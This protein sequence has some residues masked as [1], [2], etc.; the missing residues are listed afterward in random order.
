MI[1]IEGM[2]HYN[3]EKML[4]IFTNYRHCFFKVTLG[5]NHNLKR[6]YRK[7]NISFKGFVNQQKILAKGNTKLFISHCGI[8][9]LTESIYAGVPLICIPDGGDQFYLSSLI[10]HLN[11]GIFVLSNQN[12]SEQFGNALENIIGESNINQN[13]YH[14]AVNNLRTEI[15][16]DFH[17]NNNPWI[18]DIF[19]QKIE[20]IIG[21]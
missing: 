8:N 1:N 19:L 14:E 20:E 16:E 12:F 18:K 5:E 7:T 15:L 21:E 17:D 11:I 13:I 3:L 10:E 2:G 9:S 6:Y 4:D